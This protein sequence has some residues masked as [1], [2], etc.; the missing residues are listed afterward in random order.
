MRLPAAVSLL[1]SL[2]DS[3]YLAS[4]MFPDKR[5]T[6]SIVQGKKSHVLVIIRILEP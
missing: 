4:G 2:G 1:F 6:Y 5:F 3:S